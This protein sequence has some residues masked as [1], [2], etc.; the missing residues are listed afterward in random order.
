MFDGPYRDRYT[1]AFLDWLACAKGGLDQPAARAAR[2]TGDPVLALGTA[3]H[4]L[5]FDDTYAPG[6]AHLSAPTAP[7]AL[8]TAAGLDVSVG[9][10]LQAYAEGFEAMGAMARASHPALYEGGWHPTAVCGVVGAA[11]AAAC[12][13]GAERETAAAI[14]LLRAAGLQAAFGSDGKAL[15]VGMAASSG[16]VAARLAA[17]G[18]SVSPQRVAGGAGG[19]EAVFGASYRETQA[20]GEDAIRH[21][22]IKAWPCCLQTHSAIEAAERARA[23]GMQPGAP[24]AVAVHPV[25]QRAAAYG[26]RPADGL[27]AK[28]SIPYL[29]AYTIIRGAPRIESFA[30]I[31]EGVAQMADHVRVNSDAKLAESEA[32]LFTGGEQ[33]RVTAALGSPQRPMDGEA[34]SAKVDQLAGAAL[35]GALDDLER[36]ARAVLDLLAGG[37]TGLL[38][39]DAAGGPRPLPAF[40]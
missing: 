6:L 14:S 2:A 5:D 40:G 37:T 8:I 9:E 33:F 24:I 21:N 27:Q 11:T 12:L 32:V 22:W 4:V 19:F 10:M 20:D 17:H 13:L 16:V 28:F 7:A 30:G 38:N 1:A 35:A 36:P 18:A 26:P 39:P 31:D 25:S 23:E 34:L 3:G 15:Q 29:V